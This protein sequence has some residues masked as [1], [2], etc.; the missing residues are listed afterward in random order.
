M[1]DRITGNPEVPPPKQTPIGLVP[2]PS[3]ITTL[4]I[5][6]SRRERK[7]KK[8]KEKQKEKEMRKKKSQ[9]KEISIFPLYH[10]FSFFPL[11]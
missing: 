6:R 3:H 1:F 9:N 7:R 4:G 5:K 11:S 8:R 2:E 10:F